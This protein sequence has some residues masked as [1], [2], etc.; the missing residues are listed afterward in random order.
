MT[1]PE[2]GLYSTEDADSEGVEGKYYVWT[3]DEVTAVLGA[4]RA[5]EFAYV[6]DVTPSGTWEGHTILNTPRPL[7]QAAALLGRDVE[8]LR[9]ALA[10]DRAKLL[11]ARELRVPPGKDTKVLTSWNGL[12]IAALAEGARALKDERYLRAAEKAAGFLLDRMR[13]DDGRLLHSYKDG[14]AKFNAYLDDYAN[15][16]DGLTRLYEVSGTPR[17]LDAAV[18]L[19][20]V[21]VGE[22]F[23][24]DDGGF[25]YTGKG[26]ET[27]IA[28]QKDA[29]DNATPSGSAMAAT[30]LLRLG[31]LTNRDELTNR[32]LSAL[33]SV[34][35]VMEKAPSAAGQS[36]IAADFAIAPGR[37]FAV[38][39]G[40]DPAE[41]REALEAIYGRFLPHKVVAPAATTG[42]AP[43]VPLLAERP[44]REGK[45]TV[46]VCENMTCRE[47]AVGLDALNAALDAGRPTR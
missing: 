15:L 16:I 31:A 10:A 14:Q 12:M 27:L 41:F 42:P 32:G 37:E 46:Y 47:P 6:Y 26:H 43:A 1:S 35:V 28:R 33:K 11:A 4:E 30:A 7:D 3:L 39:A 19:A 24:P 18:D 23:D 45:V 8:T 20:R 13:T 9:T 36:L 25:F 40:N 2:G 17:W 21:M 34:Q 29:Y 5:K 44:A 22:F 38:V